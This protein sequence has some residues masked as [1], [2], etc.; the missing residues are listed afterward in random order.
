M[1][2]SP[3][4]DTD[5]HTV[6]L[7]LA[8]DFQPNTLKTFEDYTELCQRATKTISL[9]DFQALSYEVQ[10]LVVDAL[11]AAVINLDVSAAS[12]E[13]WDAIF[14]LFRTVEKLLGDHS[15]YLLYLRIA[16]IEVVMLEQPL[17]LMSDS[18]LETEYAFRNLD[19]SRTPSP[20][21]SLASLSSLRNFTP[22]PSE[23]SPD[24]DNEPPL[25]EEPGETLH[26]LDKSS[27]LADTDLL[28]TSYPTMSS[29]NSLGLILMPTQNVLVKDVAC[30][31]NSQSS[32]AS[33]D[34][35][36]KKG[37]KIRFRSRKRS[38]TMGSRKRTASMREDKENLDIDIAL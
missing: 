36:E 8:S 22:S 14:E 16:A 1:P 26:A 12:V 13:C 32:A 7:H 27:P 18:M 17:G 28:S 11:E 29:S 30:L 6:V 4:G 19:I 9:L 33:D 34:D 23:M 15:H 20:L 3:S 24:P 31:E 5:I 10:N 38:R 25:T 21:S 35:L 2:S 37:K